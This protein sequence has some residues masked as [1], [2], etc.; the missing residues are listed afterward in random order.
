M[1]TSKF[2]LELIKES[3]HSTMIYL[4]ARGIYKYDINQLEIIGF[5]CDSDMT[6]GHVYMRTTDSQ[7]MIDATYNK[8]QDNPYDVTIYNNGDKDAEN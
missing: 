4:T 1:V 3:L 2:Q 8:N 7:Y 6:I 5:K